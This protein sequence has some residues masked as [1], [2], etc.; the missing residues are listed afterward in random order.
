MR[1]D[2]KTE[3]EELSLSRTGIVRPTPAR[4]RL[5]RWPAAAMTDTTAGTGSHCT[6]DSRQDNRPAVRTEVRAVAVSARGNGSGFRFPPLEDSIAERPA[7]LIGPET[8][9]TRVLR[10]AAAGP[11]PPA[12]SPAVRGTPAP[13]LC[14]ETSRPEERSTGREGLPP[15]FR[16]AAN[17]L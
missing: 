12:G 7:L 4:Q 8:G 3:L 2:I 6:P 15:A 14:A 16:P 11:P 5:G 1:N 13:V 9:D 10:R 17:S